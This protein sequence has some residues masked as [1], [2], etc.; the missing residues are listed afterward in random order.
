MVYRLSRTNNKL[1][2]IYP[3]VSIDITP[4]ASH[5]NNNYINLRFVE[6]SRYER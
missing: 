3:K 1:N 5:C 6:E 4:F 2:K